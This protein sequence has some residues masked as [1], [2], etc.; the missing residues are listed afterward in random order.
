MKLELFIRPYVFE[1]LLETSERLSQEQ[2]VYLSAYED[3]IEQ[4]YMLQSRIHI[5]SRDGSIPPDRVVGWLKDDIYYI[6]DKEL[7]K[8]KLEQHGDFNDILK[9]WR[10]RGYLTTNTN[11][12]QKKARSPYKIDGKNIAIWTYAIDTTYYSKDKKLIEK[13]VTLNI[14]K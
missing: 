10:S 9:E 5:A 1:D 2:D 13:Q 12:L 4:C 7:V 11:K 6:F 14:A 3:V 8:S